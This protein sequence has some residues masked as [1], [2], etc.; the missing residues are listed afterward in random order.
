MP[1]N[2]FAGGK[3]MRGQGVSSAGRTQRAHG[4]IEAFLWSEIEKDPVYVTSQTWKGFFGLKGGEENKA[5]SRDLIV[6]LFPEALRYFKRAKDDNR[7]EAALLAVY[8]A[9]RCDLID[10]KPAESTPC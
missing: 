2:P 10:L 8:G 3:K 7:A 6:Q 4:V 9:V 1:M 5:G